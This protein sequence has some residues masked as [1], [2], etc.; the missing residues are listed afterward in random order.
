VNNVGDI[1]IVADIDADLAAF[2]KPQYRTR[3][4]VIVSEGL[5]YL[6]GGELKS[7]WRDP[8]RMVRR[9][10]DL[11]IGLSQCCAE[12]HPRRAASNQKAATRRP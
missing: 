11:R 7:Q 2:A 9:G 10:C 5:D 6:P 3:H 1:G 8:K 12:R 4:A